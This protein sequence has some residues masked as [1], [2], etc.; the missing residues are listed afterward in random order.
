MV[1]A[2]SGG[3][4][5][6][7]NNSLRGILDLARDSDNIGTVYGA[8]SGYVGGRVDGFMMRAVDVIYA[9]PYMFLVIVLVTMYPQYAIVTVGLTLLVLATGWHVT[10]WRLGMTAEVRFR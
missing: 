3:P 9:L 6:V 1:V 4:S 5:A 10:S 7:I 2:Q 8:V